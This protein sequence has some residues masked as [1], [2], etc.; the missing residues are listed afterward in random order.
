MSEATTHAAEIGS[1]RSLE[2]RV[3]LVTGGTRGI[4]AAICHTLAAEGAVI[5]AGWWGTPEEA[6][7]FRSELEATGAQA[8]LHEGNI[9]KPEDCQRSVREVIEEHGRL[10]ILVNNAGITIDKPALKLTPE[11]WTT[12]LTVNLSGAF[13]MS[14][15]AL[16]HMVE[17]GSGRII[18]ISSVIGQRGN[19]GQAN[20]AAA[21]AGL[22]GLTTS[23]ARESAWALGRND[24]LGK[25]PRGLTV[26]VV[27]PGYI[28]TP[29]LATVPEK[30]LDKIRAQTPLARLG[31]PEEIAAAVRYL[32]SD[33]AAYVTGQNIAVNGGMEMYPA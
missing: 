7:S 19:I 15:P 18:N 22:F 11:D 30:V 3:A 17:R 24:K 16:A 6:E 9:G 5:A 4:G 27:S 2:G 12:V 26:N 29:M 1:P 13:F 28:E 20:Y 25:D 33:E 31:R 8:S 10:D 23:L 21:K 32:A 14:E